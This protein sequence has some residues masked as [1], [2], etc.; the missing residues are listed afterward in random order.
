MQLN[1]TIPSLCVHYHVI[2]FEDTRAPSVNDCVV[3]TVL[4]LLETP[5]NC[6]LPIVKQ[7]K[8]LQVLGIFPPG[9]IS[10]KSVDA[11]VLIEIVKSSPHLHTIVV[12]VHEIPVV[13]KVLN[14]IS[15]DVKVI[16]NDCKESE[17]ANL[18]V[19]PL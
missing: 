9:G 1:N 5:F 14:S 12:Y 15:S 19:F 3:C 17:V 7:C 18:L 10:A 4:R 11:A 16:R 6:M 8:L 2:A 13:K